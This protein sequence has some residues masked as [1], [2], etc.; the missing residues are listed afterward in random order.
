MSVTLPPSLLQTLS[1]SDFNP[2]ANAQQVYDGTMA[3][4]SAV[5]TSASG[6]FAPGD[7]G[8]LICIQ[9]A[10]PGHRK[11]I[12]TIASYQSATQ[13]TLS[14][15]A[16]Y[17]VSP[18]TALSGSGVTWGTDDSP[19]I[20]AA[21]NYLTT[22]TTPGASS[23]GV[24]LI[25]PSGNYVLGTSI[26]WTSPANYP[27]LR[28]IGQGD[29]TKMFVIGYDGGTPGAFQGQT[30]LLIAGPTNFEL[31]N[32]LW[33][34]T[35]SSIVD[36]GIL[37]QLSAILR[38]R[39][40]CD[41]YW[42]S[43]NNSAGWGLIN[44]QNTHLTLHSRF[45]GS[46]GGN[47]VYS[48]N[49]TGFVDEG[50]IFID[51]GTLDGVNQFTKFQSATPISWIEL[52][53]PHLAESSDTNMTGQSKVVFRNTIMDEDGGVP[54]I[55]NA[56]LNAI[57]EIELDGVRINGPA[58][59]NTP[60]INIQGVQLL[61]IN[62]WIGY[63]TTNVNDAIILANVGTAYLRR[64]TAK[65]LSNRITASSTV[66]TLILEDCVYTTLNSSA[67]VT[68]VTQ[69]GQIAPP[70]YTVATLPAASAANKGFRACVSDQLSSLPA[71]G[72]ALTGGGTLLCP[73]W[74]NGTAWVAG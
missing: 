50:S 67:G 7:V 12:S 9:G 4:G 58:T 39:I 15:S 54:I 29:S 1:L 62:A 18:G 2:A 57:R 3:A 63:N 70:T 32:M 47:I 27:K 43:P 73:C 28:I 21:L 74:S 56:P 42:L 13:V 49:W 44:F 69:Q 35:P 36:V 11:L 20:Q 55:I 5:L 40:D 65:A 22:L 53:A 25:I 59:A 24:E 16:S 26:V 66:G 33:I 6:K 17:A 52:D 71:W 30:L 14:A 51:W 46:I 37:I 38:A 23:A 19:A 60:S 31:S 72:G 48:N 10:G 8:K 34:G 41:F 68:I 45:R 61:T 64:C